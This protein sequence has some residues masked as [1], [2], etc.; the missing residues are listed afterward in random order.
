M[1]ENYEQ[2]FGEELI[3]RFEKIYKLCDG[4]YNNFFLIFGKSVYPYHYTNNWQRLNETSLPDRNFS[5]I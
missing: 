1:E 2:E 5:A 3:K 4:D